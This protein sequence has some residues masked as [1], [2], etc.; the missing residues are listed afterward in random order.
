MNWSP[1]RFGRHR[2]K[3]LPQVLFSD[4]DWF[5]WAYETDA[6]QGLQLREADAIYIRATHIKIPQ[7]EE[8]T[9]V[10]EYS[11]HPS[12][13]KFVGM[14]L[15]PENRPHHE[16][17]TKTFRSRI[18]DMEVPRRIAEYDK[19]GC[20]LMVNAIKYYVIGNENARM[21]KARCEDFFNDASNFT[22]MA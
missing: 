14:D 18:I 10:A 11:V 22:R 8:E 4:P 12:V 17:S 5:F 19:F 20:K 9:L 1:L 3:T 7:P 13:Q 2:G 21:T 15:V 16:G 6:F